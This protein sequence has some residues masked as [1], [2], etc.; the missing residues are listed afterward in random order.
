MKCFTYVIWG[1]AKFKNLDSGFMGKLLVCKK[2]EKLKNI[3]KL[4]KN[5]LKI[6]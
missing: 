3:F 1:E 5:I 4:I 2:S 6:V